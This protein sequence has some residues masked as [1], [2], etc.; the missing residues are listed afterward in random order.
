[1]DMFEK[2][3]AYAVLLLMVEAGSTYD[4][5]K[6]RLYLSKQKISI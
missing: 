5:G 1:M 3:F 4:I 2:V 6:S